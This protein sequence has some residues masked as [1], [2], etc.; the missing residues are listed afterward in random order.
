MRCGV[1]FV[2]LRSMRRDPQT[3]APDASTIC[4]EVLDRLDQLE[5]RIDDLQRL[6]DLQLE[7]TAD[8]KTRLRNRERESQKT[9]S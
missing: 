7:G 1:D 6:A 2:L 5:D 4:G 9:A 8:I 3:Q